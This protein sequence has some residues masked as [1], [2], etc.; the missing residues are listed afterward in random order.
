MPAKV[1]I[2]ALTTCIH[3]KKAKEYLESNNVEYDC[4]YVDMLAGEERQQAVDEVKKHNPALSFPTMLVGGKVLVGF[5][6]E[7]LQAALGA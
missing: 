3:C 2:Y 1:K 6:K 7:E 5:N 4:T